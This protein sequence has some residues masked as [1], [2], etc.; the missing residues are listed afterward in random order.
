M[1]FPQFA[2]MAQFPHRS[3]SVSQIER[4]SPSA[5]GINTTTTILLYF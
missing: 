4:S 5:S 2:A 3:A 1:G